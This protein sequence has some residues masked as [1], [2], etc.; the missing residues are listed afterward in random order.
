LRFTDNFEFFI[1]LIHERIEAAECIFMRCIHGRVYKTKKPNNDDADSLD[2][3]SSW[4]E[5][6][7]RS[8]RTPRSGFYR[9]CLRFARWRYL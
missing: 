1:R 6:A 7:I 9:E 4:A 8:S 5:I 2:R 3:K